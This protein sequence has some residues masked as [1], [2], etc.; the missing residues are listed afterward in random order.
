MGMIKS[1]LAHLGKF[2][3]IIVGS[4]ML[5]TGLGLV[6]IYSSSLRDGDFS[7]FIKQLV[8]LGVGLVFMIGVSLFDFR[9]IRNDPYFILFLYAVGI[10]AIAGL[11]VFAPE[12]RGVRGWYKI[13]G[14]SIDPLEYMKIIMLILMA[15]YFSMRHIEMYRIQHILLS[16]IY[17][18]IPMALAYFKPDF[19]SIILLGIL[20]LVT[21]LVSGIRIKHLL[22]LLMI[23][24]ILF[25]LGWNVFLHDYQLP[26]RGGHV[27]VSLLP[28]FFSE[29]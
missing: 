14:F 8:F 18:A 21:L 27:R 15:K 5:L 13:G 7:N 29:K 17:F 11:F 26:S 16:G 24:S 2:D 20:W 19:G 4:A 10:I 23:G 1:F 9:L 25:L 6:S 22:V 12:I 3:W 28:S